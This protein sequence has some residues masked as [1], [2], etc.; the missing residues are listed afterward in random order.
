MREWNSLRSYPQPEYRLVG[1]RTISDRIIASCRGV[2]FFDG[3]RSS[4]YGGLHHGSH[5]D[6]VAEDIIQ[7]YKP[8]R[9]IELECEKG[10]LLDALKKKGIEVLGVE[11]SSYA[12][13]RCIVPVVPQPPQDVTFD[14]AIARGVVYCQNLRE[15]MNVIRYLERIAHKA[16][17]ILA[18]YETEEDL[19]LLRHW[20]LL[21]TTILRTYEWREVLK[22]CGYTGDYWFTTA[23]SLRLTQS[24]TAELSSPA[25][26]KGLDK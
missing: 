26:P 12:R 21:G 20:T 8:K 16:F 1:E 19:R 17:I 7:D 22:H 14:L 2:D 18:A 3:P 15:A 23:R 25:H 6:L 10:F 11:S 4:G 24:W 9:V 5:W 13:S